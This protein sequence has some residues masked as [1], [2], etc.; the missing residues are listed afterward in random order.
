MLAAD[1]LSPTEPDFEDDAAQARLDEALQVSGL[2]YDLCLRLHIVSL[3][4]AIPFKELP[5]R[6]CAQ[7]VACIS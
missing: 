2:A 4:T 5:Q 3:R 7:F 6:T 1:V